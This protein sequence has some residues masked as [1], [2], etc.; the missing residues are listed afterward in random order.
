[1][2]LSSVLAFQS[3]SMYFPPEPVRPG[4]SVPCA[5]RTSLRGGLVS[6]THRSR[7]PLPT[8][9][10]A[11]FG[12]TFLDN[13]DAVVY[14]TFGSRVVPPPSLV[15]TVAEGLVTG[16]WA[17]VWSLKEADALHLPPGE[18]TV[19]VRALPSPHRWNNPA[20]LLDKR[21]FTRR[22]RDRRTV[23]AA[24]CNMRWGDAFGPEGSR[25]T[26]LVQSMWCFRVY[27][28]KI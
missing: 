18:L 23:D 9:A 20:E 8:G 7:C 3:P 12:Q 17:V 15:R 5:P 10:A 14:V 1:M 26:N 11:V 19:T 2:V 16:G 25:R 24:V 6:P 13:N 21:I 27:P 28:Q 22:F 4:V